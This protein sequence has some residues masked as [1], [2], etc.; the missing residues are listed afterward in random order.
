VPSSFPVA[1]IPYSNSVFNEISKKFSNVIL[2]AINKYRDYINQ[3][4]LILEENNLEL[5]KRRAEY[6][7][8]KKQLKA[9]YDSSIV[10]IN[11]NMESQ[12]NST[13]APHESIFC[14]RSQTKLITS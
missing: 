10:S 11:K 2:K 4:V 1:K 14:I 8:E 5:Q 13:L 9:K 12:L 6:E 7:E 3:S